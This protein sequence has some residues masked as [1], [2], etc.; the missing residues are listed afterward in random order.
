[1]RLLQRVNGAGENEVLV[2]DDAGCRV[3]PG[4]ASVLELAERA[5]AAGTGLA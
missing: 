5:I 4:A 1:M 3:V 2:W